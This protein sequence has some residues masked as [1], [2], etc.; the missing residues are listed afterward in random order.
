MHFLN[1][2]TKNVFEGEYKL[3]KKL[4]LLGFSA[5]VLTGCAETDNNELEPQDPE[6]MTSVVE[7]EDNIRDEEE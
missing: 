7:D 1:V 2:R 4:L 3:K 5:L 6:E